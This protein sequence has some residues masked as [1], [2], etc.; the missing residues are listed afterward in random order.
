MNLVLNL[1]VALWRWLTQLAAALWSLLWLAARLVPKLRA[2]GALGAA[3]ADPE[4]QRHG[5]ALLRVLPAQS[6]ARPQS[7]EVVPQHRHGHRLAPLRRA[8]SAAAGRRVR[9]GLRAA[10]ADDHRRGQLLPRH[11]GQ[12]RLRARRHQ[13]AHG[14]AAQR[15]GDDRASL[16]RQGRRSR[17]RRR[18]GRTGRPPD[19]DAAGR[20]PAAGR[21]LRAAGADAGRDDRLDDDALLVPVHRPRRRPGPGRQGARRRRQPAGLH[22]RGHRGPQG[23]G[24]ASRR[25][26]GP[27]P[28]AAGRRRA[29][30]GRP[31]HPRQPRRPPDRGAADHLLRRGA[32]PRPAAGAPVGAGVRRGPRPGPAMRPPWPG[33]S[34]RRCASSRSTR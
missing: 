33:T 29:R 26:A 25:R 10:H 22:R 8:R 24:G 34:S 21:L 5:F 9:G 3:A 30:H 31:R 13:H 2:P 4:T 17:R 23:L 12:P 32:R 19:P 11:A 18:A 20:A 14:G 1:P 6:R 15:P 27:L 16:R 7:G 28:G